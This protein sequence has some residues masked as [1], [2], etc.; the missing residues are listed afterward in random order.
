MP[1]P[2]ADHHRYGGHTSSVAVSR[3]DGDPDLIVDAGTGIHQVTALLHGRAFRGSIL[4]GH[5]HWDHIY[6][7]PFFAAGDRPDS[8][9][10]VFMP[11]REGEPGIGLAE[12]MAPPMFPITPDQLRGDWTFTNL[13][14]GTHTIEGYEVYAREIPH[15]G[16]RTFG[17][18]ISDESVSIA[19]LSDHGPVALGPGDDGYGPYHDAA[20]QLASGVDLLI[21]DAQYVE[22]EWPAFGHFGHSTHTYALGLAREA[23]AGRLMMFHHDPRR[24]DDELDRLSAKW[25]DEEHPSVI[26]AREGQVIDVGD[27]V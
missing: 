13:A 25:A 1:A 16:G 20:L 11:D 8:R 9:V 27:H 3:G 10:S 21:H 18:R 26:T 19:Y 23:K 24:T 22:D 5:L 4:L 14:E 6:G 2:G 7:L 15:K 17:Y 12:V